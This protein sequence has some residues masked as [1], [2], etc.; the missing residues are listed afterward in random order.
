M[1][2]KKEKVQKEVNGVEVVITEE[3]AKK[4]L[5]QNYDNAHNVLTDEQKTKRFIDK[6][7]KAV[8]IVDAVVKK[9]PYVKT[10]I[11]MVK[12]Y[13]KKEYTQIPYK[14]IIGIVAA[15]I[16]LINPFDIIPDALSVVGVGHLDDMAVLAACYKLVEEDIIAY[17]KWQSENIIINDEN[18]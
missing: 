4:Q 7:D 6:I 18:K 14:T 9:L 5:E 1:K 11:S 12:S 15:L 17:E 10:F 16:Y 13:I 8:Q 3:E 2:L